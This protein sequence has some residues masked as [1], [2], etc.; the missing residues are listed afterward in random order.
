M[1]T[2][3]WNNEIYQY[4]QQLYLNC[5]TFLKSRFICH[6]ASAT[7]TCVT[8]KSDAAALQGYIWSNLSPKLIKC[9]TFGIF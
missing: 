4:F 5:I 2:K 8:N 7:P 6:Y 1:H 3:N 9:K